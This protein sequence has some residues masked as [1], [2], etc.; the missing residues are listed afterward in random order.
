MIKTSRLILL[1]TGL[2]C[3]AFPASA[4]TVRSDVHVKLVLADNKTAFRIGEPIKFFLEFTADRGG[5]QADTVPDR[6]ESTVDA[7]QVSPDSG[8][9]HWLEDIRSSMPWGRDMVSFHRLSTTPTRVELV[10]NDSI[11]ID[12]PGKYSAKVTTKRVRSSTLRFEI[13]R[14]SC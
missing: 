2:I 13:A 4:Q 12:H 10:L 6:S 3:L 5:Y 1:L 7:L 14:R 8:I 11:R 9:Y